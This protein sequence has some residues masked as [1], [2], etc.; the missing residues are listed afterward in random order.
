MSKII[1]EGQLITELIIEQ[2]IQKS[3]FDQLMKALI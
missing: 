1:I 3:H 2:N